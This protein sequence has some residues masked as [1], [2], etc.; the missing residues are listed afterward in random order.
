MDTERP[1]DILLIEDNPGDIRLTREALRD[2]RTHN[3]LWVARDGVDGLDFLRRRGKHLAAPR[4][5]LILLDL[6]LPRKDGREL[7]AEIKADEEL[8]WTPV[9]IFTTSIAEQDLL[10][11]YDLR[12]DCY[13][14]KPLDLDEFMAAVRS[15]EDVWL[16]MSHGVG[17]AIGARASSPRSP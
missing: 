3:N 15:I 4:P 6:N 11:T 8:K 16:E 13:I 12:A 14:V 5:D 2:W 10:T 1:I 7:L 17:P 9:V